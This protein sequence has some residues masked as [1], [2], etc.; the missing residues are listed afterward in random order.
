MHFSCPR[1]RHLLSALKL[2]AVEVGDVSN[3]NCFGDNFIDGGVIGRVGGCRGSCRHGHCQ[4]DGDGHGLCG[5][6]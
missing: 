1:Q 5:G 3:W 6:L 4:H 2:R